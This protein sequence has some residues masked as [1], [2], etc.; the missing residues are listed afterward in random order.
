MARLNMA[1]IA[2]HVAEV[3]GDPADIA[4][5]EA[6]WSEE[7]ATQ[8]PAVGFSEEV[9]AAEPNN[10]YYKFNLEYLTG[11]DVTRLESNAASRAVFKQALS[12]MDHTVGD[13]INAHFETLSFALTGESSRLKDAVAHLRDW[14]DWRAK[15]DLGLGA[16]NSDRCATDLECVSKNQIEVI[17]PVGDPIVST[18]PLSPDDPTKPPI[19]CTDPAV[20][21]DECRARRSV[22]VTDR[23]ATDFLWQRPPTQLDGGESAYHQEPGIDYL[24]PYW[25]L[26]YYTEV[27]Q[28]SLDPYPPYPGPAHA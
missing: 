4:K 20:A 26:R 19:D 7:L 14:R 15:R 10:G 27:N 16:H 28:P 5:W 6:V 21:R 2:R 25:M 22:P 13:D 12:V 17:G 23:P 1:Q 3:A 9:N 24:L 11:F 18:D 8:G